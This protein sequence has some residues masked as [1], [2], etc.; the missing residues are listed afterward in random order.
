MPAFAFWYV[1]FLL[2]GTFGATA[3][4]SFDSGLAFIT[5]LLGGM[6]LSGLVARQLSSKR[7]FLP[8]SEKRVIQPALQAPH[9]LQK[10][11]LDRIRFASAHPGLTATPDTFG[12]LWLPKGMYDFAMRKRIEKQ[13]SS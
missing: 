3:S 8:N 9:A 2:G 4:S 5:G 1:V 11:G 6:A 12:P 7:L 10:K 13:T